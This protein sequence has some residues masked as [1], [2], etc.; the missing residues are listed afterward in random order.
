MAARPGAQAARAE[1]VGRAGAPTRVPGRGCPAA[2]GKNPRAEQSRAGPGRWGCRRGE[3]GTLGIAGEEGGS[4]R[5]DARTAEEK[6]SPGS[7]VNSLSFCPSL[8]LFSFYFFFLFIWS[9]PRFGKKKNPNYSGKKNNMQTTITS[10]GLV[11]Y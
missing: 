11:P 2:P 1:G 6:P 5:G 9:I 10:S 7:S 4:V 8:C 3:R